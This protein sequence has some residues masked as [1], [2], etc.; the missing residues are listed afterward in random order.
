M[1]SSQQTDS[2]VSFGIVADLQYCDAPPFKNRFF[3][4]STHK[5]KS[6]IAE[7]NK[8]DLD[9]V[10]FEQYIDRN[11]EMK[12]KKIKKR[13]KSVNKFIRIILRRDK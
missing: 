8:N 6:A 2:L 10:N 7:F 11:S 13:Y 9:F 5:L 1:N 3:R 4:N 12:I